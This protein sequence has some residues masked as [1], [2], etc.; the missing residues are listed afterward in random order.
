M[1]LSVRVIFSPMKKFILIYLFLLPVLAVNAQEDGVHNETI[2]SVE[3]RGIDITEPYIILRELTIGPGDRIDTELIEFNKARV[4]SL[5]IFS[6]VELYMEERDQRNILVVEVKESWYIWPIPY[7]HRK[8]KD[9]TKLSYGLDLRIKNFRGR[10]ESL[11]MKIGLGFDP[12]LSFSYTIPY[13]IRKEDIS[14]SF[15]L[16][17]VNFGNRSLLAERQYGGSFDMKYISGGLGLSKRFDHFNRISAYTGFRFFES[18]EFIPIANASND[19]IDRYGYAGISYQH[20][21]RDLAQFP[22]QGFLFYT[23]FRYNG[24]GT[25]N[26]EYAITVVDI[27]Y[28]KQL[29]LGLIGKMRL[30][31]RN[32][33]GSKVPAYEHSFLGLGTFL[34]GHSE[35]R[36]EGH[37][38]YMGSA[39]INVPII[40]QWDLGFDF[41]VVP[42]ELQT[43]RVALYAHIFADAG[44][45]QMDQ[46]PVSMN[47][48]K[49]G[50]GFGVTMLVMP[51]RSARI[52]AAWNHLGELELVIDIGVS[53]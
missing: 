19:R 46:Q 28:Y 5:G 8:D 25:P 48:L 38:L 43:Y 15:F 32:A 37:N 34:R 22:T 24:I 40:K 13:F 17:F 11:G 42:K 44:L 23:D 27:R 18:P 10:N 26:I 29:P 50:Y 39:E 51:Y 3:V 21:K 9:W 52:E 53:F 14:A 35:A 12:E 16:Q 33:F 47:R 36:D 2:D 31:T 7:L 49:S 4:F 6:Y 41:P 1:R 45:T 30:L 20:D